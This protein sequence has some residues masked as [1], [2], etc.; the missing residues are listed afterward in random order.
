MNEKNQIYE[1]IAKY[2]PKDV[3]LRII[4]K[5]DSY[6]QDDDPIHFFQIIQEG[7]N[8]KLEVAINKGATIWDLVFS[9]ESFLF[10]S[11]RYDQMSFIHFFDNDKQT[12]LR[13][14]TNGEVHLHYT[15]I[16]PQSREMLKE[17]HKHVLS[18][19]DKGGKNA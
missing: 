5:V 14:H 4:K 6:V 12:Y 3:A 17:Y 13:I 7:D 8:L 2:F 15:S 11:C 10:C 16:A 18:I 9:A 19:Y 1:I